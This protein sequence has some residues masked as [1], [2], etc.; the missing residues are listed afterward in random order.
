MRRGGSSIV[1]HLL[2]WLERDYRQNYLVLR[3]CFDI[4]IFTLTFVLAATTTARVSRKLCSP[5]FSESECNGWVSQHVT[6]TVP[7]FILAVAADLALCWWLRSGLLKQVKG[8]YKRVRILLMGHAYLFLILWIMVSAMR[9]PV[10]WMLVFISIALDVLLIK[11]FW[12]EQSTGDLQFGQMMVSAAAGN[13]ATPFGTY[14]QVPQAEMVQL[15]PVDEHGRQV[16]GGRPV[17]VPANDMAR[18]PP[19]QFADSEQP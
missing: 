13:R 19:L 1:E 18:Q 7:Y 5:Y 11:R 8:A 14:Q 2:E 12:N 6:S 10:V 16:Q 9:L 3:L 17:W 15:I 4:V